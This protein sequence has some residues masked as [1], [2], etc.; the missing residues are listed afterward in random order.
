MIL[1]LG[2]LGREGQGQVKAPSWLPRRDGIEARPEDRQESRRR[3]RG[4]R[5]DE[6]L[7]PGSVECLL[8]GRVSRQRVPRR[9]GP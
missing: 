9:Q 7:G 2:S 1:L 4:E 3:T 6:S 8:E 5:M